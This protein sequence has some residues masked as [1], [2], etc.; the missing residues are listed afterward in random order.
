MVE[1][2]GPFFDV[3]AVWKRCSWG[4]ANGRRGSLPQGSRPQKRGAASSMLIEYRLGTLISE[5]TRCSKHDE[6]W[7][8]R[9]SMRIP[10][11]DVGSCQ[12]AGEVEFKR[13]KRSVVEEIQVRICLGARV[14]RIPPP[15]THIVLVTEKRLFFSMGELDRIIS[16]K[17]CREEEVGKDRPP[18]SDHSTPNL[19]A[20]G[21]SLEAERR[22][23]A[24]PT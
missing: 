15:K 1:R 12:K 23:F 13:R 20:S 6:G 24:G 3:R 11:R 9:F 17:D 4:A 19:S 18:L 8:T 14:R 22:R 2:R 16:Q 7:W 10:C 5:S 21:W